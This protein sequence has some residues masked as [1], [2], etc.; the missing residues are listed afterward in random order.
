M[1]TLH[2]LAKGFNDKGEVVHQD[3]GICLVE[4]CIAPFNE[5]VMQI[6]TDEP[7]VVRVLFDVAL[8]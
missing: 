6:K 2:I 5:I 3:E 7:S 1:K 8:G 4:E